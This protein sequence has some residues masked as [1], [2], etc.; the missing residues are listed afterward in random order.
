MKLT[1]TCFLFLY[2]FAA[3]VTTREKTVANMNNK[4]RIE[5]EALKE[6]AQ[7]KRDVEVRATL[8]CIIL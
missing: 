2:L 5:A 7:L 8:E 1:H 6:M 3:L 4:D